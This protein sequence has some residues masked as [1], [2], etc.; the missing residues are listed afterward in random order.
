MPI[1]KTS[2]LDALVPAEHRA[3]VAALLA[4]RMVRAAEPLTG[5]ASGATLL[6]VEFADQVCVL[7]VDGPPDGFR[8]PVRQNAC[9]S[10]AAAQGV[11]P[12]LIASDPA[13]RVSL[14]AFVASTPE[15]PRLEKLAQIARAVRRLHDG[16][17]FPPMVPFLDGML[18]VLGHFTAAKLAPPEV[19]DEACALLTRIDA[20]YRLDPGDVVASHNDLNPGNILFGEHGVVFIDWESAFAA[21]RFVDLAAILNYFAAD[22]AAD[23]ELILTAYFGRPPT[24]RE[25]ARAEAMRQVNRLFYACLLLMAAAPQGGRATKADFAVGGY[26]ALRAGAIEAGSAKGKIALGCAFLNDAF[27]AGRSPEFA[28]TLAAL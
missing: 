10:L 14:S 8:D 26:E 23:A 6:R 18:A 9:Q 25:V 7:R 24:R 12:A 21:D 2:P 17:A 3:A 22:S 5:G 4:G 19:N 20:A 27:R 1:A 28:A 11:A 15:P 16:P 13:T